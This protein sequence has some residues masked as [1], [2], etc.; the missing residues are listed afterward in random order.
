MDFMAVGTSEILMIVLVALLVVGPNKVVGLARTLGKIM[1][2]V[3]RASNELVS[4]V[5][6]ELDLEEEEKQ[7][8]SAP[9]SPERSDHAGDD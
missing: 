2:T 8:A 6:R 4:S 3:K 1:R 9:D 5:T 7:K